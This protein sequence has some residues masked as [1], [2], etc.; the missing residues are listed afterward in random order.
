[1][2]VRFS[3]DDE[4]LQRA[5]QYAQMDNRS[6]AGLMAEA[7]EC[8]MRQRPKNRRGPDWTMAVHS[9]RDRIRKTRDVDFKQKVEQEAKWYTARKLTFERDDYTCQHCGLTGPNL[10][11]HHIKRRRYGGPDDPS[12]LVTL[13]SRCHGQAHSKKGIQL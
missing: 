1:M 2:R 11:P 13:C 8:F 4:L 9:E 7:L 6:V 5:L 3:I 10:V 12:N